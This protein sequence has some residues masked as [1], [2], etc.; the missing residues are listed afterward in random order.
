MGKAST[1]EGFS[2]LQTID[3]GRLWSSSHFYRPGFQ[4]A[5]WGTRIGPGDAR[6]LILR[7]IHCWVLFLKDMDSTNNLV[8][9]LSSNIIQYHRILST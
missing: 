2:F 3:V 5:V 1:N 6:I 9:S 4:T 7:F 8:H